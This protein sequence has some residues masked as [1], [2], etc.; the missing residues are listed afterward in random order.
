MMVAVEVNCYC[1]DL[2][3]EVVV[4][5]MVELVLVMFRMKKNKNKFLFC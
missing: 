4:G 5:D 2:K 1:L 3:L